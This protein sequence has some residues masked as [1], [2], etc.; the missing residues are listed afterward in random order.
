MSNVQAPCPADHPLMVAWT[1]YKET[2]NFKNSKKWALT[3]A[4]MIQAGDPDAERKRLSLM[5]IE[6]R[7]AHVDGAL[8]AAFC[9]G[10]AACENL[11]RHEP[12]YND[13]AFVPAR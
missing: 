11:P 9:E 3:I 1:A 13:T 7:E 5:P 10:F 12:G 8:W 2:E 4:P 6:Q